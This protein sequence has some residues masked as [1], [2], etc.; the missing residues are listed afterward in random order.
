MTDS[1]KIALIDLKLSNFWDFL[2]EEQQKSNAMGLIV[3]IVSVAGFNR[4]EE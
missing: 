2:T 3:S 4:K 1:E